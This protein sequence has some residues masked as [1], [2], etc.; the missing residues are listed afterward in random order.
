M[1]RHKP[2][3]DRLIFQLA[4]LALGGDSKERVVDRSEMP[5]QAS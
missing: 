1:A 3:A 5:T 2:E 4:D